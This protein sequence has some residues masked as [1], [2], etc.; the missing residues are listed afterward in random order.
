MHSLLLIVHDRLIRQLLEDR[1]PCEIE[2]RLHHP[3]A[4]DLLL[5][6]DPE[7]GL[8]SPFSSGGPE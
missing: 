5:R 1:P 2:H 6:I 4:D 3:D 7:A 8:G